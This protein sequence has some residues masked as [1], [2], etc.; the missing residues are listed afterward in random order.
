MIK[1]K[2]RIDLTAD[3]IL[4]LVSDYDIFRLFMPNTNW[5]INE[6]TNSPFRDDVH[7]SFL[8]GNKNGYLSFIDFADSSKSGDAFAF[9]QAI[10]NCS[11]GE[12]L[13]IIDKSFGLG[14]SDTS[15]VGEY[16]KIVSTY[17]QPEDNTEKH[18]V[19]IQV[20][21][22]KFTK[23]ELAYWQKY[24]VDI[25]ELRDNHIYSIDKMFLNRKRFPLSNTELR[26]GYLYSGRY[27]KIYSPMA[28]KKKKWMSN[29]P[30]KL[31]GGLEN[32]N[33]EHNT[34]ICKA[35]KD[36][37]VCRK[38]YGNVCHS[39]NESLA[40]FSQENVE[41]IN[42]NSKLVFYAGDSDDPGKAASRL[43]TDE[44][45]WKHINPPDRLLPLVKDMADWGKMS[46]KEIENH[47][48]IKGLI[49]KDK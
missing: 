8:I 30:L 26:F 36:Q 10:H 16:K 41:Y 12:A 42:A 39:Q 3:N 35:L 11:Y 13:Q 15:N 46:L 31:M 45:N 4:K 28:T 40:A 44:F 6:I 2:V 27:W 33:K 9:T 48:I 23:E 29:V 38:V 25:Q 21:T 18:A 1:G 32:L 24:H 34:L 47:F 20:V 14:I 37:I 43:I 5:K 17:K 7:P 19:M 49:E 22:R